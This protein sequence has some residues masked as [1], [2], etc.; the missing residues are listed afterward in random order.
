MHRTALAPHPRDPP[1]ISATQPPFWT[2]SQ[3]VVW[4]NRK[5]DYL[6]SLILSSYVDGTALAELHEH[7]ILTWPAKKPLNGSETVP[8]VF[9]RVF[10]EL[11]QKV[12][13]VWRLNEDMS[14]RMASIDLDSTKTSQIIGAHVRWVHDRMNVKPGPF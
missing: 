3:H 14:A 7:D 1:S 8:P 13:S 6:D 11:A 2:G 4:S 10:A 5:L 12:R 9:E